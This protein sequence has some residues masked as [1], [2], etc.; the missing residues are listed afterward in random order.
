MSSQKQK[1]LNL[2]LCEVYSQTCVQGPH[3]G[4]EKNGRYAE[5]GMKK[6]SG[7]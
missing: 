3:L 5:G 4:L 2:Q 1:K 6:I 7:K